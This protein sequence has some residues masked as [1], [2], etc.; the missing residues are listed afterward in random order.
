M[1][2]HAK[3]LPAFA[4]EAEE[5]RFWETHD[6]T[7]HVTGARR[8]NAPAQPQAVEASISVRLP[9]R[10]EQIKVPPTSAICPISR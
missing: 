3:P 7:G 6:S 10:S 2:K 8:R 4:D 9:V 1:T 5:R